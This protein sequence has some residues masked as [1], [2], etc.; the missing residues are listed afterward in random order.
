[1]AREMGTFSAVLGS[2]LPPGFSVAILDSF[3]FLDSSLIGTFALPRGFF[4][5]FAVWGINFFYVC[6]EVVFVSVG[7]CGIWVARGVG[8]G[9][10]FYVPGVTRGNVCGFSRG[11]APLHGHAMGHACFTSI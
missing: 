2:W 5:G 6:V 8:Y 3:G 1:M 11:G 9:L 10:Y 7:I 4:V